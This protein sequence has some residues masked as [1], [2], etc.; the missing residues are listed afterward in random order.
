MD[1]TQIEALEIGGV[2]PVRLAARTT[3]IFAALSQDFP[4]L[5]A[6]PETT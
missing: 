4:S 2:D 5:K 1:K 3:E 6:V